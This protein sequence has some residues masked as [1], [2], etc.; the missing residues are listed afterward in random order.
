[1]YPAKVS[2]TRYNLLNN[3]ALWMVEVVAP[4][5][6]TPLLLLNSS[7]V[8][9]TQVTATI[10][11][12]SPANTIAGSFTVSNGHVSS[13]P[14]PYNA[15]SIQFGNALV[16]MDG[17]LQNVSVSRNDQN[18]LSGSFSWS[19]TFPVVVGDYILLD[20][21]TD[22]LSGQGVSAF[23]QEF[24]KGTNPDIQAI[25]T[26]GGS[27][28]SGSFYLS[29]AGEQTSLLPFNAT[30][31]QVRLALES[32]AAVGSLAVSRVGPKG[33]RYIPGW[34]F[35][36]P[37]PGALFFPEDI[38]QEFTWSVTFLSNAGDLAL[39]E[40]CCDSSHRFSSDQTLFTAHTEDSRI[41]VTKIQPGSS[42]QIGGFFTLQ[43]GNGSSS[44]ISDPIAANS[45]ALNLQEALHALLL[46]ETIFVSDSLEDYNG[47]KK[48]IITFQNWLNYS[49]PPLTISVPSFEL[50]NLTVFTLSGTQASLSVVELTR[51][52]SPKKSLPLSGSFRLVYD[53]ILSTSLPYNASAAQVSNALRSI[54]SI[55][56]L[57]V[58]LSQPQQKA[59]LY[60]WL[61]SF[62]GWNI[63][64]NVGALFG[65]ATGL[66]GSNPFVKIQ[67]VSR[68]RI[69]QGYFTLFFR[70][71]QTPSIP[72]NATAED[73][74][75]A[76]LLLDSV[77]SVSVSNNSLH[78][79]FYASWNVTFL[80]F[81]N[82]SITQNAGN[83]PNMGAAYNE[84]SGGATL[85]VNTLREG[86]PLM[87][88][89]FLVSYKGNSCFL[90]HDASAQSLEDCLVQLGTVIPSTITTSVSGDGAHSWTLTFPL[91][92]I[93][94]GTLMFDS[95]GLT[96]QGSS[97]S[98]YIQQ[99]GTLPL[100]GSFS[101]SYF[102]GLS[103]EQ[104]GPIPYNASATQL[105]Q[106]LQELPS[107]KNVT[108]SALA[109][110]RSNGAQSW[111][112]TF[113]SLGNAGSL[114][115]LHPTYG[116]LGGSSPTI[117]VSHVV[118][119][120]SA[121]VKRV[122]I[123][124]MAG[125]FALTYAGVSTPSLSSSISASGLLNAFSNSF[126]SLGT[127]LVERRTVSGGYSW[128][129]LFVS[130][131]GKTKPIL[132]GLN[133]SQLTRS[134]TLTPTASVQDFVSNSVSL[135]SGFFSLGFG[136]RCN[137]TTSGIYCVKSATL[138]LH[139]NVSS[140]DLEKSLESLQDILDVTV[141]RT[142]SSPAGSI[143]YAVVFS[144]TFNQV[145]LNISEYEAS[146]WSAWTWGANSDVGLSGALLIGGDIP[147]LQG[148]F[149]RIQGNSVN[150]S[151]SEVRKGLSN[152]QGGWVPVEVTQNLQDFSQSGVMFEYRRIV[153]VHNLVP[154]HGPA[155]GGTEI[156]VVGV[157]FKNSSSLV[158]KF[159]SKNSQFMT[160]FA[161]F[162]L[163]SSAIICVSPASRFYTGPVAVQVSN[164]GWSKNANFS[165]TNIMIVFTYDALVAIEGVFPPLGPA[166]GNFS[167]VIR[168][169]P[170]VSTRELR[171]KFGNVETQAFYV[172]TE[173]INCKGPVHQ[174][175]YY[176]LEVSL[177][178]QDYTDIRFPF[179]FYSDPHLSRIFPVSG[180]AVAAG[181]ELVVYGDGFVNSS[182]LACRF[183][184]AV[185]PGRYASASEVVCNTPPLPQSSGGM[186]WT[187][188][189]EQRN[190]FPDPLHGSVYLFPS[191]HF[192]PLYQ[193]RLVTVEVSNNNQD[194]TDSG[195]TFLYQ[196]DAT[197]TAVSP[198]F[199]LDRGNLSLF[200]QGENFVNSTFLMCRIGS[201]IVNA[202]FLS[203]EL[204]LCFAPAQA[205][206]EAA[207]GWWNNQLLASTN[208]PHAQQARTS[209]ANSGPPVVF[210]EVANNGLDFTSNMVSFEYT[211]PC[212]TGFF[213]SNGQLNS[214][215][216]CPKGSYCPGENNS[217][218]TLCPRGTYQPKRGQSDCLRCPVGFVC[219]EFGLNVP[220]ICP[221][222]YVCDV[223]GIEVAQQPCPEGH[224]CLEGTATSA[225]T[226]GHPFPSSEL[227]P[228]VTH[229]ETTTT[230]RKG[231]I[232][233]G[234]QLVLGARNF[235]C[236]SNSSEDFGLQLSDMPARFWME[237]HRLPLST[238]SPFI[239]LRGRYCLDDSCLRLEDANDLSVPDYAWDYSTGDFSL[240]RPVPCPAGMYCHAGTAVDVTNMK[241]YTTPQPCAESIYCPEGTTEPQGVGE[242]PPGFYCPLGPR[243]ACPV[244]SYCPRFG[245]WMPLPCPPGTFSGMT[246][247]LKCTDCPRGYI[248]PGFGRVQPSICPCG[249]VCSRIG[250][251]TPNLRCPA[252]FYCPNGTCTSDPFR[253]DTTLRPYACSPGTYCLAGTCNKEVVSGNY[254]YAQNCTLGFFCEAAS[255][256]A[257]GSGLC[258]LGFICPEGTAVPQPTPKGKFSQL[259]GTV[260]PA[261]CLPGFYS[262][263]IEASNCYPCPPGTSC[264]EGGSAE[265]Q[266]CPPG[267][268]RSTLD[269]DGVLCVQCPQGT[270]SKNFELQEIGECI[271]CPTGVFCAS[272]AMTSPCSIDDL[273]TPF[274]PVVNVNLSPSLEYLYAP[275][276]YPYFSSQE[277]LDLNEGYQDGTMD[278]FYQTYFYG[279][280]LYPYIDVLG[281]GPYFRSTDD[282]NVKY[283]ALKTGKCYQNFKRF[284]S[285]LYQRFVDYFGPQYDIQKG[286]PNQG[287]GD[288][289]YHNY[290]GRGSLYIDLPYAR[291]FESAYNCT[292]GIQLFDENHTANANLLVYTSSDHDPTG[293]TRILLKGD[294]YFYPGTC[295]A[296]YIC[297]FKTASKAE[298][299]PEGYVC[300][301][302]STLMMAVYYLCRQ[303]YTCDFGT[304]PDTNLESPAGQFKTLC[305]AGYICADGTTR[306]QANLYP[307]PLNFFCPTGTAN[308]LIGA[309][310]SDA[311][312]RNLN[313]DLVN[314]FLNEQNVYYL[315]SND[316]RLLSD[317][318][319]RCL[320][321]VDAD[322]EQ[323]YKTQWFGKYSHPP[324]NIYT[325]YLRNG[326]GP[327]PYVQ[328]KNITG[329]NE[330]SRPSILSWATEQ[331]LTCARDHK[332]RHVNLTIHRME[333]DCV[334][335]FSVII[336]VYRLWKCTDNGTL[337]DLGLAAIETDLL[338]NNPIGGRNFWFPQRQNRTY[339]QCIFPNSN[340]I[341]MTAGSL[342][343]LNS[344][345]PSILP[346]SNGKPNTVLDLSNG[347]NVQFTWL[348][349]QLFT[350]YQDLKEQVVTEYASELGQLKAGTSTKMDPFIFDLYAAVSYIEEF[351]E[352][353]EKLIWI[354][355]NP[356]TNGYTP[357]RL[358]ACKCERLLKCPNGTATVGLASRSIYDCTATNN[359]VLV[360]VDVIPDWYAADVHM[361]NG[362]DFVELSGP[363]IGSGN[364]PI[365]T[366][367][368]RTLEVATIT[369]N[370][371]NLERN[372]TYG[373][374]YDIGV[375][376]N[377]KP[378]PTRYQCDYLAE[379]PTCDTYP[380]V[381]RQ[382][383]LYNDCLKKYTLTTCIDRNGTHV[384]CGSG[385]M[386][387]EGTYQE[388]DWFKCQQ[389]PFFCDDHDWPS[390]RWNVIRDPKTNLAR[391]GTFQSQSSFIE[392][393]RA[394][395]SKGCCQCERHP[396]P[397]YYNHT[398][399]VVDIGF[400]DNKHAVVQ[401][402]LTALQ[403]LQL[404]VVFEL[405]HGLYY[406]EF[407]NGI[408][409]VGE[410]S[411]HRPHMAKFG[412]DNVFLA[413]IQETDTTSYLQLPYN[414]PTTTARIPESL[415][416]TQTIENFLLVDRTTD[417]LVADPTYKLRVLSR[418]NA[419]GIQQNESYDAF[420]SS[421]GE[422]IDE[423]YAVRDTTEFQSDLWWSNID[424]DLG[425]F[426]Y[427]GLPYL[428]FFSN[429]DGYGS[430][431]SISKLLEENPACTFVSQKDTKYVSEF[432]LNG[433]YRPVADQCQTPDFVLGGYDGIS[434]NCTYDEEVTAA[435]NDLRWWELGE[436]DTLF[437]LTRDPVRIS[438]FLPRP[439]ST[440]EAWGRTDYLSSLIGTFNLRTVSVGMA[441]NPGVSMVIPR[442]IQLNI[443]YYQMDKHR[444]IV[445]GSVEYLDQCTVIPPTG[446][447]QLLAGLAL[448]GFLPCEVDV[449][450]KLVDFSYTL[451]LRWY[452]LDWLQLLN[453][454]Q[455]NAIV[456]LVFFSLVGLLFAWHA[457]MIWVF[458]RLLTKLLHPPPFHLSSLYY[459]VAE[460]A[461]TGT[462]L[463]TFPVTIACAFA[464]IWFDPLGW[465]ASLDPVNSPNIFSFEN[466][467][468]YFANSNALDETSIA[469]Y[470]TGRLGTCFIAIGFYIEFLS[471]SLLIPD[472]MDVR[473][474]DDLGVEDMAGKDVFFDD[475]DEEAEPSPIWIPVQ[476][477][478]SHAML[479]H[480]ISLLVIIVVY[481]F[482]YS[483]LFASQCFYFYTM[484]VF[485]AMG[486]DAIMSSF[487]RESLVMCAVDT[488]I[489]VT[490][491]IITLGAPNFINFVLSNTVSLVLGMMTRM[492]IDPAKLQIETLWPRW[493]IIF[494][495]RF[496]KRRRMTRE[497]KAKEEME[498]RKVN[499]EIDLKSEG[500]EPLLD[501]YCGYSS[502]AGGLMMGVFLNLYLMVFGQETQM[503]SFWGIPQDW[504]KIFTAFVVWIIPFQFLTDVFLFNAQ[505]LAHGWRI[506]DYLSYQRYRFTVRE[507]RWMMKNPILDE[508]IEDGMQTVD[509][510]CFS[511]QFYFINTLCAW[512]ILLWL[513]GV[514]MHLRAGYFVFAD[515]VLPVIFMMV[516]LFGDVLK[517]ILMKL[518]D[519]K[520]KRLGW[521]GLWVTKQIEGTVDDDVAAKLATGE[522]RQADLE[523]ERLELQALNSERFRHRFLDRNRPWILQHLVEL[524]TPRSLEGPGPDGRPVVEYIRDV[525]AELMAMGE[526]QKRP[527]D[528]SDISSESEDEL[529]KIRRN[530]PRKPLEGANLAIARLWLAKARK[531]LA[532]G[533][534]VAGIIEKNKALDCAICG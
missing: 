88:G 142:V 338:N 47:C 507:Y 415:A 81:V 8:S 279:E 445:S 311:L 382:L 333:C 390:L 342:A 190:R 286:Y 348:S 136:Q 512:G 471:L 193:S 173:E 353:L 528:R 269:V 308:P 141:T 160:V 174:P 52:V 459:I 295:E 482:S 138:P 331:A 438:D 460:P 161:S 71:S 180:P 120:L 293:K 245:H 326:T 466:I 383:E 134:N 38:I 434:L 428:P 200:V 321:G 242:C 119:G 314:P 101:L 78:W 231:R 104:T 398:E 241:N 487:L 318:D 275:G 297:N 501:S 375:Y 339:V 27:Q 13:A 304:T 506:F 232:P 195:I 140:S 214:I 290:F 519:I 356:S 287:Y 63:L 10:A 421:L 516:F 54:T 281:R 220:R 499:E 420:Y 276:T 514:T 135:V 83:V 235:G 419:L 300:E 56:D 39:I 462:L 270:W 240:R 473:A 437:Y 198:L 79:P 373:D 6:N 129:I 239:P 72:V 346:N 177:N 96:G 123:Q 432:F 511:S 31:N 430:H 478:R 366:L 280:L 467:N 243:I 149:S 384:P 368:L 306:G 475:E 90:W 247:Q 184:L 463:S 490:M 164:N 252:G 237:R 258:P 93:L 219:P 436:G 80:H 489:E 520:F 33:R 336:A 448:Q 480:L 108:V 126:P 457:V 526:G 255:T 192:Y 289:V 144:I 369:L 181:T 234:H 122:L 185:V 226:C 380:T 171:C 481:E 152:G 400:P 19:V 60:T 183:G 23:V 125:T 206:K 187:A 118:K 484:L 461:F 414:L 354:E 2:V 36:L 474:K 102:N 443:S 133:P 73:V 32:L 413:V 210:V 100:S 238:K 477:K 272:E 439:G 9:G 69:P 17:R 228:S 224:F 50:H 256:S 486:F 533:R 374:H 442:V 376:I 268:Y 492:Y 37:V 97:I 504:M 155:Y 113:N 11:Q 312:N 395:T 175:G 273:P 131:T 274:E 417:I 98:A 163:N 58:S 77:E 493:R 233:R 267:T 409:N 34:S 347:L 116:T 105:T 345:K 355:E 137:E 513:M 500:V 371:R 44:F 48:W 139:Y 344:T 201:T 523:Q 325:D 472:W 410:L 522:G 497:E 53:G 302:Q 327:H 329:T 145:Y 393:E 263:T 307:C 14:L 29:Y 317:H 89:S 169:G 508:S 343:S 426:S 330:S 284:G 418:E 364:F 479:A 362:T 20:V 335:Q 447:A 324:A 128:Y 381:D 64:K 291:V 4:Y 529:E 435:S 532:F 91:G 285:T 503:L 84:L 12:V 351:G 156:I 197:V 456:Y 221:A 299:C 406:P 491:S 151:V 7:A 328:N 483:G 530:W 488:L 3:G 203:R 357:G 254:L 188:L 296:D 55:S 148:N 453:E 186:T 26:F 389:I 440:T 51:W 41:S 162:Y 316:V 16:G 379:P 372:L 429:C 427:I 470:K 92:K 229:A 211:G 223:T 455:F 452:P 194:F 301:Q 396:M 94:G 86:T 521:R 244:G 303:G 315:N 416:R 294:D 248:C 423:L 265:A 377:C 103:Y 87:D 157:N 365:R 485:L 178:D 527:G 236:W 449:N 202:T 464:W 399:T 15:S 441:G 340:Q 106:L 525:Y 146:S 196:S 257:K 425:A 412:T 496:G 124:N 358:D 264:A 127:V 28:L 70:G 159:G 57:T 176:A 158:C 266:V 182:L 450:G 22:G 298:R 310:A 385:D 260:E 350:S 444:R 502:E 43:F 216:P 494:K 517:F 446:N 320:L 249:F 227:F 230:L 154:N 209:P 454:F 95:S 465:A 341:N 476:W 222:G 495:R 59:R 451:Q 422:D 75:E 458:N 189:S 334:T 322:F 61:V 132:V 215:L 534:L 323:R 143:A 208:Y 49:F 309:I 62:K 191:A 253:N 424:P 498:W 153:E 207:Q 46:N 121:P 217:N 85:Q 21:D 68:V 367:M 378:C 505:E 168:G 262:P 337:F 42:E 25:S 283:E 305:P 391:N 1:M 67:E 110:G 402:T 360:R 76:L 386:W 212:P 515:P 468:G 313:A 99:K 408:V 24:Q 524:L 205:I 259:L 117:N 147:L 359:E 387:P 394:S 292:P 204:L 30:A 225:T 65:D 112:I 74:Q 246:G 282:I 35:A 288:G 469:L 363:E 518:A 167:V 114:P 251:S 261:D 278:P 349:Q 250:L 361:A 411:V 179:F 150:C 405:L 407:L 401:F 130:F 397:I 277:C 403:D 213:C 40:G 332:W 352:Y 218:F 404:T 5:A 388:P 319:L 111:M 170:F 166:S 115:L 82:G 165:D 45:S 510:L 199:G 109:S 107:V 392:G 509:L 431:M 271:R 433:A 172:D 370:L 66:G 18:A 531:R